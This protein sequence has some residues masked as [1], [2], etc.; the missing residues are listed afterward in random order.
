MPHRETIL[1]MTDTESVCQTVARDPERRSSALN[2]QVRL[3]LIS[4]TRER[5]GEKQTYTQ[6]AAAMG[7]IKLPFQ[8]DLYVKA[9][10]DELLLNHGG[11]EQPEAKG[12]A[13]KA[14]GSHL[15]ILENS[16]LLAGAR[17]SLWKEAFQRS[18]L[19]L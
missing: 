16:G 7:L 19:A 2:A 13:K 12:K 8:M 6:V 1:E 9:W 15:Q 10:F 11:S 3:Q 18:A 14:L 4:L 17:L 5:Q